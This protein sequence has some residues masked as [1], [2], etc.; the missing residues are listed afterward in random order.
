MPVLIS[1]SGAEPATRVRAS[2]Y[3][4]Q[5]KPACNERG[6]LKIPTH[7]VYYQACYT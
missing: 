2:S 3:F 4:C 6:I 7:A 5:A 1:T